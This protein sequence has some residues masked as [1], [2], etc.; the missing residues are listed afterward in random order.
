MIDLR[1]I[2][3]GRPANG[4][5]ISRLL[6]AFLG[7]PVIWTLHLG[8]VYFL[9]TLDCIS[10]WS[11]AGWAIAAVTLVCG[12]GSAASGWIA[13]TEH[14]RLPPDEP[15][16]PAGG[17]QWTRFLLLLGMGGAALFTL[18][19]ILEGASPLFVSF[20]GWSPMS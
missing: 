5:S 6:F 10:A 18:V 14:R 1:D 3:V 2:A 7:A 16:D 9:L 11:G 15:A 20:C 13:L 4:P 17:A 12:A 8:A 19:I